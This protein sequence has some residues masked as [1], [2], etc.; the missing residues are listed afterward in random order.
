M[1]T[2]RE[3]M[4][5]ILAGDEDA[6]DVLF[7]RHAPRVRHRLLRI[8]H[9]PAAA[10]DLVQE[11]FLRLWTRGDQWQGSGSLAA[12]LLRVATNL[13]LNHL[14]SVRRRRQRP[15]EWV[16][17]EPDPED[18][19]DLTPGWM[20]DEACLRPD[21]VFE[22]AEER[23]AIRALIDELPEHH[24][25]VLRMVHEAEMGIADVATQLGIPAGTVK[26]RLHYARARLAAQWEGLSDRAH[27]RPRTR[28]R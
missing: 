27:R 4:Q 3:L 24:Q 7:E 2:D 5:Q 18:D 26:S 15:L 14:R 6:F 8:V 23:S 17:P 11:V 25:E 19:H 13:A 10:D 22:Q 12:W 20:V 1:P 21:E 16:Q 9:N 28:P